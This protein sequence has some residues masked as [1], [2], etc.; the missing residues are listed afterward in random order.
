MRIDGEPSQRISLRA[1]VLRAALR[2]FKTRQ[3]RRVQ[4]AATVRRRLKRIEPFVPRP[5]G[6]VFLS[7]LAPGAHV[8]PVT[9][10]SFTPLSRVPLWE[11]RAAC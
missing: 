9:P 4:A 11:V 5:P 10:P 2:F 8:E 7:R 6:T 3:G 1:A